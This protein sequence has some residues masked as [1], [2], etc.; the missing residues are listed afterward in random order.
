MSKRLTHLEVEGF[1]KLTMVDFAIKKGVTEISGKN[2]SGKSS[3]LASIEV[4]LDGL[5][6]APVEPI[7][8]HCERTRIR[9][10]IG[11]MDVIRHIEHG[12]GGKHTTRI[13]FQ[14]IDGKAYPATQAQ[15][16][17]LIGQHSLDPLDFLKLDAKGLFA[18]FQVF[19]PGFNF[20]QAAIDHKADYDRRTEVNRVAK[21]QRAAAGLIMVP[22]NTPDEPI[23]E[24]ELVKKLQDAGIENARTVQRRAN[25]QAV[26]TK[27]AQLRLGAEQL[28]ANWTTVKANI[29]KDAADNVAD[30][31]R[32][33]AALQARI[34]K[35][36]QDTALKLI[37]DRKYVDDK[38]AADTAEAQTLEAQL[39]AAGPL[40]DVID[41]EAL[42]KQI[43][44]ARAINEAVKRKTERAKH[45]VTATQYEA[46]SETLT[47]SIK[48]REAAKKKAIADANLPLPG[49]DLTDGEVRLNGQPFE[50]ASMAE[51]L[52]LGLAYTVKRNPTLRLAWIRDASLLDDE[53]YARVERLADEF[54][55]DVLLETVRP[56]GKNVVILE[57]GRLKRSEVAIQ[58]EVATA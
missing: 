38:V 40:P 42:T 28:E 5:K 7:N 30:C 16:N 47:E 23:D 10:R 2:G 15:L 34:E 33:I 21:E 31:E 52:T 57:D 43:S 8:S 39:A 50:Q 6:V 35:I 22:T 1:M 3:A 32:Q 13:Q 9:G 11:E 41:T 20:T 53:A 29:E 37:N 58:A 44:D 49:L 26:A 46:E 27:A 17:D 54:D 12:K 4:L 25:R 56:I 45:L 36:K 55:C 18:A 48:A 19:V 24:A 51:K 14:P